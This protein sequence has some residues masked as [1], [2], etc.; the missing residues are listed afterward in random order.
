MKFV[1]VILVFLACALPAWG[2][3]KEELD[4][5]IRSLAVK[6]DQMQSKPD[7]R[8]PA[9]DL[10]KARGIVLL[11]RTKAGFIFAYQGGGGIA[12]AK[13]P[14]TGKW[15]APAFVKANEASLG[16]QVGGQQTF[17]VILLMSTN[18]ASKLSQSSFDFGG[19]AS[20]TIGNSTGKAESSFSSTNQAPV[21]VYTDS[22]GLY[23]GAAIKGGA[24]SS[25]PDANAMYYGQAPTP[26]EILSGDKVKPSEAAKDLAQ[27]ITQASK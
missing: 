24:V 17:M 5:R 22:T 19:E 2:L 21:Q 10:Q 3:S 14:K 23:G 18:A 15:S 8:I 13:Q 7:K 6:F 25:D 26:S 9:A 16:A 4:A 27:K 1:V 20:G 11:D 12:L